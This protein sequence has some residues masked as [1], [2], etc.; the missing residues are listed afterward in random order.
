MAL[1]P[2]RFGGLSKLIV[3]AHPF[4]FR[5]CRVRNCPLIADLSYRRFPIC[6]FLCR[7]LPPLLSSVRESR[8]SVSLRRSLK[9]TSFRPSRR[10]SQHPPCTLFLPKL[11]P[12][13]RF[14]LAATA[15]TRKINEIL[16][17]GRCGVS[18]GLTKRATTRSGAS[19]NGFVSPPKTPFRQFCTDFTASTR[20][21]IIRK[22]QP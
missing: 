19:P 14:P 17:N 1:Y 5:L 3:L 20:N 11:K 8:Q 15:K 6:T 9:T 7:A 21:P 18:S 2:C 4:W 16:K 22:P 13:C 12:L 10:L